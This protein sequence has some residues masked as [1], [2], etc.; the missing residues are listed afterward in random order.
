MMA[1]A[2]RAPLAD[3]QKRLDSDHAYGYLSV[4]PGTDGTRIDASGLLALFG[5]AYL[6][7]QMAPMHANN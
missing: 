7:S 4:V 2:Q 5:C 6:G 3:Y 1:P